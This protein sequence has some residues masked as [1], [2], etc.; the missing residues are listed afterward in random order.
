MTGNTETT[1]DV[2]QLYVPDRTTI[3]TS[4]ELQTLKDAIPSEVAQLDVRAHLV[5]PRRDLDLDSFLRT[6]RNTYHNEQHSARYFTTLI[7][8]CSM[9]FLTFVGYFLRSYWR[10]LILHYFLRRRAPNQPTSE[11]GPDEHDSNMHSDATACD[12]SNQERTVTFSM[13]SLH[14]DA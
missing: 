5:T 8:L 11:P 9:I 2:T 7:I 1:L 13:Y 4:H 6:S 10:T 3:V 12:S 14:P